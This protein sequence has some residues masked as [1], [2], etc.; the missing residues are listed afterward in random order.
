M[1]LLLIIVNAILLTI[2]AAP[3]IALPADQQPDA[4]GNVLPP[5]IR[6]YFHGWE[7]Y[8]LFALFIVFTYVQIQD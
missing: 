2:Q 1:I 4:D 3:N 6:G 8:A 7:D 5:R